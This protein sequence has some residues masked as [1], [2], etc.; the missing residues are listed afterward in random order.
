[1]CHQWWLRRNNCLR[2]LKDI[3]L[4]VNFSKGNIFIY[5]VIV[6]SEFLRLVLESQL[7]D[8]LTRIKKKVV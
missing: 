1:M 3:D 6:S 5:V 2:S 8:A 7:M 4:D